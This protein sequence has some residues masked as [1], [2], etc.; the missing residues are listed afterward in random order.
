MFARDLDQEWW[1]QARQLFPQLTGCLIPGKPYDYLY[2]PANSQVIAA[3]A[4]LGCQY[5][6]RVDPWRQH[7]SEKLLSQSAAR[8]LFLHPFEEQIYPTDPKVKTIVAQAA[9]KKMAVM[10]ACGYL[11][12]S[13]PCQVLPLVKEFPQVDFILTH[14]AQINICGMHMDEAFAIF[15]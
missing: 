10:L 14:G 2:G 8:V 4:A 1:R 9:K 12:F 5:A 3:A 15:L 11:P 13:H 7:E 6:L